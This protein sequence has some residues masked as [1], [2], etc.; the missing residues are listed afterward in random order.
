MCIWII[1]NEGKHC[2][3][4]DASATLGET[5]E[6]WCEFGQLRKE[7]TGDSSSNV[8]LGS[9]KR[10]AHYIIYYMGLVL[11]LVQFAP[12]GKGG[13]GIKPNQIR[14]TGQRQ[15]SNGPT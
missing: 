8:Q 10:G 3:K 9:L 14:Q 13:W 1:Q 5:N 12:L 6:Y 11:E 2:R 15:Y 4:Y 7:P